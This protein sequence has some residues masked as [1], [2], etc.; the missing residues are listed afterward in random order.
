M[1]R[2]AGEQ[3]EQERHPA[4]TV[5]QIDFIAPQQDPLHQKTEGT[6]N[7]GKKPM[8]LMSGIPATGSSSGDSTGHSHGGQ[9]SARRVSGD[10]RARAEVEGT[11]SP[12]TTSEGTSTESKMPLI[13][14]KAK[15][16][17]MSLR[18]ALHVIG[19]R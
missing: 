15:V 8:Q 14:A 9:M 4:R 12:V 17:N 5:T 6:A 3:A 2:D 16:Q 1:A 18:A 19:P 11:L 13:D 10:T 7:I